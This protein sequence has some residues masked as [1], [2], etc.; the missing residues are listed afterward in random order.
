MSTKTI[1]QFFTGKTLVIPG[2]QRD[3]AWTVRNVDDIFGDVEEALEAG[4]SH[5]LGTFI[6]S[7]KDKS[8]HVH[9]VDGQQRLTTLTMLLDALIDTS[10]DDSTKQHYRN[11]FITHP[12]TGT[13]F[14]VLGDNE[15]F[16]S[17]LL[18]DESPVAMTDGQERLLKAY[19]WI[20]HRVR[21]LFQQGGQENI[22][23]WLLCLSRMEVLEFIEPDE[24]KAIRMFQ[25]VND[26]GVPLAKM[27]I[28]KSLLVYYSNRY[29]N[30][31]LDEEVA[32][33]FGHAY[34]SFSHIKRMAREDGY[35]VRHID[36][37]SFRE[38]DVLRAAKSFAQMFS[39]QLVTLD[40]DLQTGDGID[41]EDLLEELTPA[42]LSPLIAPSTVAAIDIVPELEDDDD[43][44]PF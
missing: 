8:A 44:V 28:V 18:K 37:D 1:E 24:G 11:I 31:E 20:R 12:V 42:E 32:Q 33:Q 16:F 25:S 23:R 3:Y 22:N 19:D 9:V 2:Y 4:G 43:D 5:Y 13:K 29:L 34:R 39:G 7:Q 10:D 14:R 15:K 26:R 17:K 30:G 41:A 35:K 6:L 38:D 36:R 21:A 27:D 40:D